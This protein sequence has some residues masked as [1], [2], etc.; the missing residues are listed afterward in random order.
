MQTIVKAFVFN[1][2]VHAPSLRCRLRGE[3][4]ARTLAHEMLALRVVLLML[5][6]RVQQ[7]EFLAARVATI[8]IAIRLVAGRLLVTVV[9]AIGCILPIGDALD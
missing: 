9:V 5:H 1:Y 3:H 4:I 2:I 8:I 7:L 6:Q